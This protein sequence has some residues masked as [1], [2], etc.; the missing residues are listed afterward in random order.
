M[1][2]AGGL[3]DAGGA[4]TQ[5]RGPRRLG[6]GGGGLV[7]GSR[8]MDRGRDSGDRHCG[9][10]RSHLA[11]L[12]GEVLLFAAG[13][14]LIAVCLHSNVSQLSSVAAGWDPAYRRSVEKNDPSVGR[15]R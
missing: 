10:E 9:D 5:G 3:I 11:T 15:K 12:S 1:G 14:A 4:E 2:G 6:G 7:G 8:Q 13:R